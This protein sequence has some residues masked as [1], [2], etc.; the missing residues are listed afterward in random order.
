MQLFYNK[1][2]LYLLSGK[3]V[4]RGDYVVS[5][6]GYNVD[7]GCMKGHVTMDGFDGDDIGLEK[8]VRVKRSCFRTVICMSD[9]IDFIIVVIV[10]SILLFIGIV[11]YL[12]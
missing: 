8:C 6:N 12:Y 4:K 2:T 1:G 11:I 10:S 9:L 3:R 5:V 7:K